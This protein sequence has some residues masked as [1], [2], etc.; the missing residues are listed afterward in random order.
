MSIARNICLSSH[1]HT[2]KAQT[3]FFYRQFFTYYLSLFKDTLT[4]L[5]SPNYIPSTYPAQLSN[6]TDVFFIIP[7]FVSTLFMTGNLI[8]SLGQVLIVSI[9]AQILL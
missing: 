7:Q 4:W 8:H 5:I 2:Y 9:I 1:L 6:S 3:V